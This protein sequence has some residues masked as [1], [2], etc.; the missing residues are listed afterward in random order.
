MFARREQPERLPAA[1]QQLWVELVGRRRVECAR[2][3]AQDEE[4]VARHRLAGRDDLPGR[5][6]AVAGEQG[7]ERFV[8]G[9]LAPAEAKRWPG[10]LVPQRPP[11]LRDQ[12]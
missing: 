6:A 4:S 7:H 8:L 11:E 1:S 12:L 3:A 9:G 10:I 5:D 2:R